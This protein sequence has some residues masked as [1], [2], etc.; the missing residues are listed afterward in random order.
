MKLQT[1]LLVTVSIHIAIWIFC[2]WFFS[3]YGN[4]EWFPYST[5]DDSLFWSSIFGMPFNI[6]IFYTSA[7]WLCP[8]RKRLGSK[9]FLIAI[10]MI[11][12]CSFLEAIMDA[13]YV[14]QDSNVQ[15]R[16][17][18]VVAETADIPI[19]DILVEDSVF[20]IALIILS[21]QNVYV[22]TAMFILGFAYGLPIDRAKNMA[23]L[24]REK[25]QSELQYLKAQINPHF[26]FNGINSVYHLI[27]QNDTLAK[28]TLHKFS[29]LLRYQLYECNENFIPLEKEIA[30]LEDYVSMEKIRRCDDV[31]IDFQVENENLDTQIAPLLLTPFIENAFKYLSDFEEKSNYVQ[32][33]LKADETQINFQIENTFETEI[34]EAKSTKST[35]IGIENVKKRLALIYPK[36][37]Q[38]ELSQT[39]D[40]FIVHLNIQ[41]K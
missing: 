1:Q 34:V 25:V 23:L 15:E 6:F 35:G 11:I 30:Y 28:D 39:E 32:I 17:L 4:L 26:L 8:Y 40:T 12:G 27:G 2:F 5:K 20:S 24:K 29:G 13:Y 33:S 41:I 10:A 14:V 7:L 16:M 38:L 19:K 31:A 37:H 21:V 9:Y 22:H 18:T 36:Q 3:C